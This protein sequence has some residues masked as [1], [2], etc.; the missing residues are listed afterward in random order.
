MLLVPQY[1]ILKSSQ[2][3]SYLCNLKNDKD[4]NVKFVRDK[5]II[6]MR[7]C[8]QEG[9]LIDLKISSSKLSDKPWVILGV[10][11]LSISLAAFLTLHTLNVQSAKKMITRNGLLRHRTVQGCQNMKWECRLK[12]WQKM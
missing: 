10:K 5:K 7:N 1:A 9:A 11:S 4:Y 6:V 2:E 12:N 8:D 3:V